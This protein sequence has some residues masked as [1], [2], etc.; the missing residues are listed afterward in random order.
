MTC[1]PELIIFGEGPWLLLRQP[2]PGISG[3]SSAELLDLTSHLQSPLRYITAADGVL[4]A[5][6]MPLAA[7]G[8]VDEAR[9]QLVAQVDG[10]GRQQLLP[11]AGVVAETLVQFT[12]AALRDDAWILPVT[13]RRPAEIRVE[14][15]AGGA[16]VVARLAELPAEPEAHVAGAVA[17]FACRAQA[18][19]RFA[20]LEVDES[21]VLVSSEVATPQLAVLPQSVLAVAAGCRLAREVRALADPAL[22]SAY[23]QIVVEAAA[24]EADG[25]MRVLS[26][27]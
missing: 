18:A 20:R 6:E 11:E 2:A 26:N 23:L 16:R 3:L 14:R 27:S 19:L 25:R 22:A 7:A 24:C 13:Q 12:D 9:E 15:V 5:G 8:F 4:L 1:R 21:G 17:E 10:R